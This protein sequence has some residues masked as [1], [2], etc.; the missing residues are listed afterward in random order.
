[1]GKLALVFGGGGA[2][3]MA[4]IGVW[5]VLQEEG[6]RPD[7]LVGA[8]VGALAAAE[9]GLDQ[10]WKVV[11]ERSRAYMRVSGFGKYGTKP[12][13][14]STERRRRGPYTRMKEAALK[15]AAVPLLVLRKS[16]IK[17]RRLLKV[18]ESSLPD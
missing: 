14:S 3:G 7:L 15:L 17:R 10:D 5:K 9:F 8:S 12:T 11:A 2:R 1:M 4:H 18:I 13:L 16:L 6:I